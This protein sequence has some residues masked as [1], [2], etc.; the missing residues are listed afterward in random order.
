[1]LIKIKIITLISFILIGC[2]STPDIEERLVVSRQLVEIA[3]SQSETQQAIDNL[4]PEM[5]ETITETSSPLTEAQTQELTRLIKVELDKEISNLAEYMAQLYSEYF[6]KSELD[7][8]VVILRDW[9]DGSVWPQQQLR[10]GQKLAT[11]L[12]RINTQLR[13]YGRSLGKQIGERLLTQIEQ[14][15][16]A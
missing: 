1:M 14:N 2:V 8:L 9:N 5:L 7:E 15:G 16:S 6:F 11:T 4:V 3:L 12:P 10:L 13:A